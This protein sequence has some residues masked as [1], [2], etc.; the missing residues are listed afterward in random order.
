MRPSE[1]I[2][3]EHEMVNH[4]KRL[5]PLVISTLHEPLLGKLFLNRIIEANPVSI[6]CEVIVKSMRQ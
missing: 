2:Q 5:R 4:V 3:F 6:D 1:S